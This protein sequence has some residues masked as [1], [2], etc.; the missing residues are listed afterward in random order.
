MV[1]ITL[2]R[3]SIIL[4]KLGWLKINKTATKITKAKILTLMILVASEKMDLYVLWGLYKPKEKYRIRY[5]GIT[6]NVKKKR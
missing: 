5:V 2:N 4:E 6:A 3:K 1:A